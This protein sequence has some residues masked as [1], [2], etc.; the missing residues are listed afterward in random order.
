LLVGASKSN[1]A[2]LQRVQNTLPRVVLRQGKHQHIKPALAELHWL[3]INERITFKIATLTFKIKTTGHPIYLKN[4]LP[5]YEP[6]R[7]LRSSSKQLLQVHVA[8]TA[9]ASRGFSH[10]A[11][12]I[13]NCLPFEI[14]NASSIDSFK[15]KL[16][17]HLFKSVFAA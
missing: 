15:T 3:P 1:I 16:K 4:L 17:T 8:K 7:E 5:D 13:W 9:L 14:K 12:R 10:S 11:A 6:V 2:Q